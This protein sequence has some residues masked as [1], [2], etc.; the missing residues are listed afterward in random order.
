MLPPGIWLSVCQRSR[1]AGRLFLRGAL[2]LALI[3]GTAFLGRV[4]AGRLAPDV[5]PAVPP[6]RPSLFDTRPVSVTITAF[7]QRAPKTVTVDEL[8]TDHTL[9]RQMHIGDW[10][11]VP[12]AF[13][14]RALSAMLDHYGR[15][16]SGPRAWIGLSVF[17]WDQ[18]PQ[19]IRALAYI[20]MAA[21]WT[22]HYDVGAG[23]ADDPALAAGTVAAIIM[24]ESWFEH[25]AVNVNQWGNRD[26]GLAGCSDGCRRTLGD[27]AAGGTLDFLLEDHEYFDPWNGTRV[28]AVWFGRE[29]ARAGGDR[30]LA[31]AAYY[32]GLPAAR[33][34]LGH[35]YAENV[36]RLRQLYIEG[37]DAPPAWEFLLQEVRQREARERSTVA[38]AGGPLEGT[39]SAAALTHQPPGRP[40]RP[41]AGQHGPFG[42]Q[43]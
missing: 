2:T 16:I 10:D 13:R 24:A 26:L 9:W 20:R 32:R 5:L 33:R 41:G 42:R 15:V 22:S 29:L 3:L 25:R 18:I 43:P 23:Y 1:M 19:P 36:E 34:G 31:V 14:E 35:E 39:G 4:F 6:I 38:Y 30:L 8:L 28:A 7:W 37:V 40:A 27:M 12:E 21:Y 11:R 17:D